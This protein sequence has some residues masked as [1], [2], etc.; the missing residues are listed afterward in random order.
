MQ[1]NEVFQELTRLTKD[2]NSLLYH[3]KGTDSY[4]EVDHFIKWGDTAEEK[5]LQDEIYPMLEKLEGIKNNIVYLN[6]PVK[7]SGTLHKNERGRYESEFREYTSGCRIEILII[8]PEE[9]CEK[10]V[11]SRVEH[12]GSD[13]Y[14]VGYPKIKMDGLQVRIR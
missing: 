4:N 14:I 13:Y 7:K 11:I 10:W 5:M 6:M 9:E 8:D 12:N 2:I 3:T 1:S